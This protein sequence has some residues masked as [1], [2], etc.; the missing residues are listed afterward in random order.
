MRRWLNDLR[1]GARFATQIAD[2]RGFPHE[3]ARYELGIDDLPGQE[4]L[5]EAKRE[6]LR[7]TAAAL[8]GTMI[9]AG[10]ILSLWRLAGAPTARRGYASAAAIRDGEL[11]AEV[12]GGTCLLST[13]LYNAALLAGMGVVERH[14][15]SIDTYGEDRYFELGRDATIEYGYRDLRLRNPHGHALRVAVDVGQGRVVVT[16][17][18]PARMSAEVQLIVSTPQIEAPGER[19]TLD[20]SLEAGA[21]RVIREGLPGIRVRTTRVTRL[22]TGEVRSEDLGP[23]HYQPVAAVVSVGIRR[24]RGVRA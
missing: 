18:A 24:S 12:G 5:G 19:V 8:D 16:L 1:H 3:I 2:A 14:N 6:N 20:P 4:R 9:A 22:A 23:S 17:S 10:E 15:H 13:V 7:L 11:I 21:R